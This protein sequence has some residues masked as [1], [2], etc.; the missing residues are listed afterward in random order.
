[1]LGEEIT[2]MKTRIL[3]AEDR[4][5]DADLAEREIRH[6]LP[7]TRFQRVETEKTF[8]KS[9]SSF[10]PD[11]V[12]FNYNL[13]HFNALAAIKLARKQIPDIPF[14]VWG[15]SLKEDAI[16]SIIRA[17]SNNYIQKENW[18]RLGITV[19]RALSES[20]E[21]ES[22]PVVGISLKET[23]EEIPDLLFEVGLSGVLYDYHTLQPERLAASS[24]QFLGKKVSDILPREVAEASSY[25]INEAYSYGFSHGQQYE[26][27]IP[28]VGKRKYALSISRKLTSEGEEP[29]FLAS[30]YDITENQ[31]LREKLK[32]SEE[33]LS[34]SR[35]LNISVFDSLSEHIAILDENGFIISVNA[36][37][38]RFA[39]E[40]GA[41]HNSHW[42]IGSNYLDICNKASNYPNANEGNAAYKGIRSVMN[43][44]LTEFTMDYPCNSPTIERWFR[45][46]VTPA[47]GIKKGVVITHS[48]ITEQKNAEEK[49]RI[50]QAEIL[51]QSVSFN[52]S[53]L[54]S[55]SE[56]IAVLDSQGT[57]ILVN[58]A[59]RRFTEE[60][61]EISLSSSLIGRTYLEV[62]A[63][64]PNYPI[65][66]DFGVANAGILSVMKGIFP[67]FNMEYPC[68]SRTK[69][70]WFALHVVPM[71]G[72]ENGVVLIHRNITKRK[73]LEKQKLF[74]QREKVALINGTE[75]LI[76]SVGKDYRLIAAND[77]FVQRTRK[78]LEIT[79][80]SGDSVLNPRI[81]SS[82]EISFWSSLYTKALSG[83]SQ[84]QE[85]YL[86]ETENSKGYWLDIT[87][88]P[89]WN[90]NEIT[91]VACFAKNITSR[92]IAEQ[93]LKKSQDEF[94]KSNALSSSVFNS[95]SS[96]MAVIN[97]DGVIIAVNAAWKKFALENG[98]TEDFIGINYIDVC[99]S[100]SDN[101]DAKA[102]NQGIL[103][104]MNG[105]LEEF[106]MEYPCHSPKEERW[107]LMHVTPISGIEKGAVIAHRNITE[108]K[109]L[110]RQRELEHKEKEHLILELTK[111]NND[112]L[113][114]SFIISHNLRAPLS[115]L[116]G[117]L[118]LIEDLKIEDEY[119]KQIINGFNQSTNAL[120]KTMNDLQKIIV[121]RSQP[122]INQEEIN[123]S[124]IIEDVL[125]Q[126]ND[127]VIET[128]P[129][130]EINFVRTLS[131][132][133]NRTYMESILM[134]LFTNSIKFR[135]PDRTLII[136]LYAKSSA[137]NFLLTFTDNGIGVDVN[138]HK[139]RLFGLYQ[140]FHS[141]PEGKGFGLFLIK[142]QIESLGGK[143][144]MESTVNVG[145]KFII[146]F[147]NK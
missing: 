90:E 5:L 99:G 61:K 2:S 46:N 112:L 32:Q 100:I 31:A 97:S 113:Q 47:S 140:K 70:R 73:L 132:H 142:S 75:D 8:L 36:A 136:S 17:G 72:S 98:T 41:N 131:L 48:N 144:K 40:N 58:A 78:Y 23:I 33:A 65:G 80:V 34:R 117:L 88:N 96:H 143:I 106:N 115:N 74:E 118:S 114:F 79:I 137:D 13:P 101:S 68:H 147:P 120:Y 25:A 83:N 16:V 24:E 22:K 123:L 11:L 76:W 63:S 89:I 30:S 26:I 135:A 42:Y 52:A 105:S 77:S 49:I 82:E 39:E 129:I 122:S 87:L 53:V 10:K 27:D 67:D 107:F 54:D 1:M 130:I 4:F 127:L 108:R 19:L 12:L 55:L 125:S 141:H 121:I 62:C 56:Q 38:R 126:I 14:L 109:L 139:E 102:A 94:I 20:N 69:E 91:G 92:K 3:I 9:L 45:M 60:S 111:N 57:L 138:R 146:E 116:L 66:D 28:E 119:L 103:S 35:A 71:Y 81:F 128:Q 43:G 133:F 37:W 145:T 21:L 86:Q 59:W 50:T 93:E 124:E 44:S 84:K 6:F 110:E 95:L 134:N 51:A 7:H 18:H 104:V 64:I 15:K 85:F 29:R